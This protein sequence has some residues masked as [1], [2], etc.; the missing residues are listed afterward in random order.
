MSVGACLGPDGALLADSVQVVP[1]TITPARRLTYDDVD[2]MLAECEEEDE[3]DLF[4]LA[5]LAELRRE[6]R[7]ASG[8]VEIVMPESSVEVEQAHL[9]EPA[10]TIS[11]DDQFASSAR[12][13]GAQL[14]VGSWVWGAELPCWKGACSGQAA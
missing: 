2:E 3:Q 5:R 6:H 10:V 13:V 9:E 12:K 4:D 14:G 7:L 1:S 8:A 11:Q